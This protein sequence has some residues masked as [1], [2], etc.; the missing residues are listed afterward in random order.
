MSV[1]EYTALDVNGKNTSGI[2]DAE[3]A[4]TARQKLRDSKIFPVS[5]KE[6]SVTSE[7]KESKTFSLLQFFFAKYQTV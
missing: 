7:K 6:V 1:Y 5:I 2:V 3:S 4:L